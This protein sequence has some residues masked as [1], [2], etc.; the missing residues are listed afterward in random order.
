MSTQLLNL[1]IHPRFCMDQVFTNIQLLDQPHVQ[2][3]PYALPALSHLTWKI[4]GNV[5][6]TANGIGL[7]PQKQTSAIFGRARGI[8]CWINEYGQMVLLLGM[9]ERVAVFINYTK[10]N[11]LRHGSLAGITPA[12]HFHNQITKCSSQRIAVSLQGNK[13]MNIFILHHTTSYLEGLFTWAKIS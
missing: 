11:N 8:C 10:P 7:M 3:N 13:Y 2:L 1:Q 6:L 9:K 5:G 12:L 4:H